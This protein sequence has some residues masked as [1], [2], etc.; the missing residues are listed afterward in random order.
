MSQERSNVLALLSIIK[1]LK[2]KIDYKKIINHFASKRA[3][4][5]RFHIKLYMKIFL[6]KNVRPYIEVWL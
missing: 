3:R 2:E 1:E 4:K 5:N 6:K